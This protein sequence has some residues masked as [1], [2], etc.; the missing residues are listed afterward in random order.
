MGGKDSILVC[1]DADLDAAIEGVVASA[2]GFSGQKCS[3]CSRAIVEATIYDAF[4]ERLRERVAQP[5]RG[6]P[7]RQPQPRPGDQSGASGLDA[8]LHRHRQAGG[9]ADRRRQG[10]GDRRRWLLSSSPP[11]LPRDPGRGSC[12]GGDLW[13]GAGGDSGRQLRG[14]PEGREQHGI[15]AHR[16]VYTQSNRGQLDRGPAATFTWATS[17]STAN[18]PGP[19]WAPTRLAAST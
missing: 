4:V 10:A 19:W 9:K 1:A 2:F 18:A 8:P 12:P 15:R 7:G 14:G 3:A 16:L 5:D 11:S 6:R 13:A 17:T